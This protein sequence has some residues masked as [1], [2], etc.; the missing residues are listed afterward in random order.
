M[1]VNLW[2]IGY[3]RKALVIARMIN[4]LYWGVNIGIMKKR[5]KD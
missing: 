4:G 5:R 1:M 3:R 2:H